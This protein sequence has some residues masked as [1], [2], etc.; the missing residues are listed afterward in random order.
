M[1]TTLLFFF[2][3]ASSSLIAQTNMPDRIVYAAAG[4]W[5]SP[6]TGFSF[7]NDKI[8]V[9]TIGEPIIYGGQ[10]GTR[11]IHNGFEQPDKLIPISPTVVMLDKPNPTFK[12]YPNPATTYSIIEGPEE[13][14]DPIKLQLLD[15]N[16]K[17]VAEY[18]ME[19]TRLQI[20][21][22]NT[23]APG[24]YFLNFYTEQGQ[25]IQQNKLIKQ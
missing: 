5:A 19:S 23:L 1:K 10:V 14:K 16:A 8:M 25:F 18:N 20:D 7:I 12:V 9:Y 11:F 6:A 24:T 21:F 13:Q 3:V 2:L 4:R 17:L 22:E 15:V